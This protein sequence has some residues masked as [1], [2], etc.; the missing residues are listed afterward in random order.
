MVVLLLAASIVW[1]GQ[2][3]ATQTTKKATPAPPR[4]V[5]AERFV[6]K[7][8]S[9][10]IVASLGLTDDRPTLSM[11]APDLTERVNLALTADGT[12]RLALLARDGKPLAVLTVSADGTTSLEMTG[13]GGMKVSLA[14]G[15]ASNGLTFTDTA[16]KIR[17]SLLVN[18]DMPALT[19]M[20][21]DGIPRAG[22]IIQERG[23]R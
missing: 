13:S 6:V 5:E 8:A 7:K 9:G 3:A 2:R 4:I 20:A 17:T 12:P 14:L 15:A 19:L 10:Q 18:G 11:I 22:L 1:M 21:K 23:P 16:G